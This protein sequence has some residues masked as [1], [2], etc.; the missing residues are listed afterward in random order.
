MPIIFF[1]FLINSIF[2]G[3]NDHVP[4]GGINSKAPD[5]TCAKH[6]G[7][8]GCSSGKHDSQGTGSN[9][10]VKNPGLPEC[11]ENDGKKPQ[12]ENCDELAGT[13]KIE[14]L[15]RNQSLKNQSSD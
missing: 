12:P 7:L 1:L 3:P 15:E 8:R 10:C 5:N 14:C 4:R 13:T 6:P 11:Q 9:K 2:A